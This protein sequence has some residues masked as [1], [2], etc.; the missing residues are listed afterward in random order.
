VNATVEV[1]PE[2][3]PIALFA[4]VALEAVVKQYRQTLD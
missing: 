1:A 2:N 3:W 4:A